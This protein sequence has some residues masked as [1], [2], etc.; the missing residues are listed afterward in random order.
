MNLPLYHIFSDTSP[1]DIE[2]Y[3]EEQV[4]RHLNRIAEKDMFHRLPDDVRVYLWSSWI[5]VTDEFK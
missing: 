3:Y 4:R 1:I 2:C 5:D